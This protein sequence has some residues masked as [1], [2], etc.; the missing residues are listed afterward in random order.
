MEDTMEY[1]EVDSRLQGRNFNLRK[2]ANNTYLERHG[3]H[4]SLRYHKTE[5]VKY[6]P[7]GDTVLDSGGWHTSTTKERINWG[8]PS[9]FS[10]SQDKG[11]WFLNS[12]AFQDGITIAPN[13]DI[14]GAGEYNPG[15]NNKLK[16]AVKQYAEL[17]ANAIPLDQPSSGDCWYCHMITTEGRTLGDAFKDSDH[18]DG[19]IEEGYIV[20]SLVYKA[21]EENYNAPGAFW[22]A[23]KGTGYPEDSDMEFGRHAVKRAVYRYILKRKGL[24]V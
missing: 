11:V 17:C 12:K 7:N 13:G 8:L 15:A 9:G 2:Y 19:H 22:Q 3:G 4:L 5:V 6:F 14:K 1:K 21:L 16:R 20:P 10:L 24:T 18:I 23:F